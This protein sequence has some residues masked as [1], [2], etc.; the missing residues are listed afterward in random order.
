MKFENILEEVDGFG[1]FQIILIILLCT[2]RIVLP[3]HFLLNIFIAAVPPHRCDISSLG[4]AGLFRNLT[5]GQRLTVSVPLREDG[6]PES[7]EMFA[8]PQ[9]Q[10]L[11]NSSHSA[12]L[13]TVQCRSGWV[14][15]NSTFTSTLA[16][17]V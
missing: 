8:E 7:C 3:C 6:V 11:S 10:L 15:D 9:L 4:D 16:T 12:Q 14:Y 1:P 5:P 13:P 2:P 17:E